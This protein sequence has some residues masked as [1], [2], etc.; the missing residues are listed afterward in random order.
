MHSILQLAL[1]V[2]WVTYTVS[3]SVESKILAEISQDIAS[4]SCLRTLTAT[5]PGYGCDTSPAGAQGVLRWIDSEAASASFAQHAPSDSNSAVAVL[6]YSALSKAVLQQLY[7]TG[8]LAGV[9]V[10]QE[11]VTNFQGSATQPLGS[12]GEAHAWATHGRDI[13]HQRWP[14]PVLLV[15]GEQAAQ[16]KA[17]AMANGQGKTWPQHAARL[18]YPQGPVDFTSVQCMARGECL[19]L[20]G[21]S[22][23]GTAGPLVANATS[24]TP[25]HADGWVML[26]AP[27]DTASMFSGQDVGANTAASS[28]AAVLAA[29]DAMMRVDEQAQGRGAAVAALPR[30]VALALFNGEA[31]DSMGS[32]RFV[33]DIAGGF[34]CKHGVPANESISGQG[35]CRTPARSDLTFQDL[36]LSSIRAV[37]AVDQIGAPSHH[38]L[39]AHTVRVDWLCDGAPIPLFPRP[40]A[41]THARMHTCT[42]ILPKPTTG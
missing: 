14:F 8:K 23:W 37:F 11:P 19:P 20:G 33:E 18:W 17:Q 41:R 42:L 2:C 1:F 22:I 29:F 35:A 38:S 6:P 31:W 5:G 39:V 26:A 16:I 34:Q 3:Q 25:S 24:R 7:T 30:G 21:Q 27:M 9:I 40:R 15:E 32:T 10:L 4:L 36:P 12:T 13:I 28:I